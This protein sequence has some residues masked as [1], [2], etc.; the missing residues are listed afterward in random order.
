MVTSSHYMGIATQL[1][2][3]YEKDPLTNQPVFHGIV[4]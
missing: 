4:G 3:D 1:Y 2:E